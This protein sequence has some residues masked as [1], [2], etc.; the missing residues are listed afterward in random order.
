MDKEA[1]GIQIICEDEEICFNTRYPEVQ[2]N[3]VGSDFVGSVPHLEAIL[4]FQKK[5]WDKRFYTIFKWFYM[6]F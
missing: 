2:Q 4:N 3:L 6:N 1:Q 5:I